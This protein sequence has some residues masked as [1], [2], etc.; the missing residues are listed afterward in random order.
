MTAPTYAVLRPGSRLD[1]ETADR[2]RE[3]VDHCL[4]RP[5][6]SVIVDLGHTAEMDVAG[7]AAL[8]YLLVQSRAAD[9]T[10]AIAGPIAA[11]VA[12]FID[13]SGF[14]GLFEAA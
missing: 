1:L 2:F 6:R 4:S 13:Y 11:P 8:A 14:D 7:F 10:V 9:S 5:G 12:R 3:E